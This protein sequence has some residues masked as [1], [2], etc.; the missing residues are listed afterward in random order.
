MRESRG[1]YELG[2]FAGFETLLSRPVLHRRAR[3]DRAR[4]RKRV[5][6]CTEDSVAE[7]VD[8]FESIF[9]ALCERGRGRTR[10]VL[11]PKMGGRGSVEGGVSMQCVAP[12]ATLLRC[13]FRC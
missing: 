11:L 2:G 4:A 12:E 5:R 10:G 7:R 1:E 8:H 9:W 6:R 3:G 13:E